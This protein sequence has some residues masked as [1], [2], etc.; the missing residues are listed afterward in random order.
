METMDNENTTI[1]TMDTSE[2]LKL[3]GDNYIGRL[4]YISGGIPH[5]NPIAY[6]RPSKVKI[7]Y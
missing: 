4:A 6:F 3:L 1:K 7:D 2:C 5:I